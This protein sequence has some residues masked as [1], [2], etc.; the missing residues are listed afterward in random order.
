M[1]DSDKE[2]VAIIG[3]EHKDF[4]LIKNV[5]DAVA[6]GS[7]P[8]VTDRDFP[9]IE[10]VIGKISLLLIY[11]AQTDLGISKEQFLGG[12][13]THNLVYMRAMVNRVAL[14]RATQSAPFYTISPDEFGRLAG[15]KEFRFDACF[16]EGPDGRISLSEEYTKSWGF[17]RHFSD[18]CLIFS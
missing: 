4:E 11:W 5:R 1:S 13:K 8:E 12:L 16:V 6:H 9:G 14:A 17:N 7:P 10:I 18:R 3:L 2:I 15:R